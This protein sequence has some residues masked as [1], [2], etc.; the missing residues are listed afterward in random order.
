[1]SQIHV[2]AFP[3]LLFAFLACRIKKIKK[4]EQKPKKLKK[5]VKTQEKKISLR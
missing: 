3:Y 5:I 1:M 2:I 4:S